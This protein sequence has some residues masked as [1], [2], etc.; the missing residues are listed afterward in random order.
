[1]RGR[2]MDTQ[3]RHFPPLAPAGGR[4][5]FIIAGRESAHHH[6][7]DTRMLPPV[8]TYY[9]SNIANDIVEN[10]AR[11][12]N[13]LGIELIQCLEDDLTHSQWLD[14]IFTAGDDLVVVCDI[15][16]FP[17]SRKAFID[18]IER[19]KAGSVIGLEQV[20]NH[21]G[22]GDAYAGP[23]FLGCTRDVFEAAGRPSLAANPEMDAGQPLTYAA[24][25]NGV[26]VEMI[27][28]QFAIQPKWPLGD[29]GIFGIGKIGRAHV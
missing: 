17:L 8:F 11:V 7:T 13:H 20:A 18:F 15:D 23:M 29:R 22:K 5:P 3:D 19:A 4:A 1:M 26:P 21:L 16:A 28:P 2:V 9:K 12:F 25:A 24:W 27:A 6:Q 10:Q 14:R